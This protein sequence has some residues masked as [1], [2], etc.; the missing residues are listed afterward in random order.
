MKFHECTQALK[1][2][3]KI[4]LTAWE[5]AYWYQNEDGYLINHFEEGQECPTSELFPKDMLWVGAG[6]WEIIEE[7]N[8]MDFSNY[9]PETVP[10]DCETEPFKDGFC[11]S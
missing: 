10:I 3:K 1:E 7:T 11:F 4:K 8:E 6:D 2:G 5:N 9:A